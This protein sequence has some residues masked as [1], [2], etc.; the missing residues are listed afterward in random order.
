M[1]MEQRIRQA[2]GH[3]TWDRLAEHLE[4]GIS[5]K[6]CFVINRTVAASIARV[7]QLWTDPAR[8]AQW[9]PPAGTQMRVLQATIAVGQCSHFVIEGAHGA[10]HVRMVHLALEPPRR[11]VYTQQFVDADGQL[12]PAPGSPIWPATLLMTVLLSDEAPDRTRIT[13][14]CEPHGE[15]SPAEQQAFAQERPGMTTGWTGAFDAL[16]ALLN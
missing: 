4:E 14:T 2:G 8:L 15:A 9:M 5:G 7:F 1:A 12:A 3:A 16:E 13:V 10:V 6:R 11:L